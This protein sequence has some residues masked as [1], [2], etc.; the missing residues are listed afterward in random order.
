MLCAVS[1][2][3]K[4][5]SVRQSLSL[6]SCLHSLCTGQNV[7]FYLNHPIRYASVVA[8]IISIEP[9]NQKT[10][11]ITLDDGSGS[12]ID[13]KVAWN[14]DPEKPGKTSVEKLSIVSS[15]GEFT[16][17]IDGQPIDVGSV[18]VAK[19]TFMAF[20]GVRQ[21][22]LK[23]IRVVKDTTVEAMAWAAAAKFKQGIL[24][25]PWVL[26]DEERLAVDRRLTD[27]TRAQRQEDSRVRHKIESRARLK[28][29]RA[30][31]KLELQMKAEKKRQN[32]E[33][34]MNAGAIV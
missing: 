24:S 31:K 34:K 32:A 21:L 2:G 8:P 25:R 23:I 18:V 33:R 10:A 27:E 16:V 5:R 13:A 30:S 20:R 6:D 17:R 1:P 28:Q 15:I 7:F 12:S 9:V 11:L 4:V 26:S 29:E 19:G 22:D 3:S 14:V